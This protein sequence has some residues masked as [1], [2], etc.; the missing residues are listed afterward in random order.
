MAVFRW[1]YEPS[2]GN[3]LLTR[4]VSG[5]SP[6]LFPG[7]NTGRKPAK[8]FGLGSKVVAEC[9]VSIRRYLEYELQLIRVLGKSIRTCT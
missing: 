9:F 1:E 7:K 6:V 4:C 2:D 8:T 3:Q 5:C